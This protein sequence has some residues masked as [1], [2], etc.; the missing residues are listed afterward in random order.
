MMTP[1]TPASASRAMTSGG[2]KLRWSADTMRISAARSDA[3]DVRVGVGVDLGRHAGGAARLQDAPRLLGR[4]VAV[5]APH[6]GELGQTF[7]GDQRDHLLADG[8]RGSARALPP[9]GS[10]ARRG[11]WR[12]R[13]PATLA[14]SARLTRSSLS[15]ASRGEPVAALALHRGRAGARAC[16]ASRAADSA[17]RLLRG[18]SRVR[19]H[20]LED[21]RPDAPC[22]AASSGSLSVILAAYSSTREPPN[23]RCVWLSTKP[24]A[25]T[26]PAASMTS[27]AE[28]STAASTAA[29]LADGDDRLAG[30]REPAVRRRRDVVRPCAGAGARAAPR[31]RCTRSA[32]GATGLATAPPQAR[33]VA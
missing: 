3:A 33:L 15:S 7:V 29:R 11:T 20:R 10:R 28:Q 23:T 16:R 18:A 1:T 31:R 30:D 8:C 24:G 14:A 19:S 13:R 2:V 9:A 12:A 25:T 26:L 6:V 22:A 5:V 32:R 21:A 17:A 4:V 27:A